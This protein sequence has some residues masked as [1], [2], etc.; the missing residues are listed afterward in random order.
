[1]FFERHSSVLRP[2][3]QLLLNHNEKKN[4]LVLLHLGLGDTYKIGIGRCLQWNI[5]MDDDIGGRGE[6]GGV[7]EVWIHIQKDTGNTTIANGCLLY[8][9]T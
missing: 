9:S 2:A 7:P 1:M 6:L 8:Y 3:R 5:A 4:H